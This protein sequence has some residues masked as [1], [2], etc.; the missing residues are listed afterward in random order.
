ME[1]HLKIAGVLLIGLAFL[2]TVFP[3]R[4][5][6]KEE[7]A[8]L[9][10]LSR[11]VMYVH[12]FFI[13]LIILLMGLLCVTS[14]T[15]LVTTPLGKR[16]CFGLAI[17]WVMRLVVQFFGYSPELW[18]G[19]PFETV[20]HILF[21]LLWVYLSAVFIFAAFSGWPLIES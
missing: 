14:A 15:D 5:K 11:Q 3:K 18:R 20:M 4:F 13:A 1:L 10:L 19:K 21:S 9:S 7:L 12:T 8:S 17:F 16:V 6:W 2:H